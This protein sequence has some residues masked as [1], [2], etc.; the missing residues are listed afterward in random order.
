[1]HDVREIRDAAG[2]SNPQPLQVHFFV[3]R[4]ERASLDPAVPD[5]GVLDQP[6]AI[7]VRGG[8]KLIGLRDGRPRG[9]DERP[10]PRGVPVV[11]VRDHIQGRGIGAGPGI[12][13]LIEPRNQRC[14]LRDL[15]RNLAVGA[16][17][18]RRN[19]SARFVVSNDPSAVVA[20][21]VQSASRPKN[22]A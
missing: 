18:F 20:S 17:K 19:S 16:L 15:V 9:R 8:G 4:I 13:I 21:V 3:G 1:M 7:G 14:R 5:G 10:I 11:R 12:R 2:G 22:H 6:V